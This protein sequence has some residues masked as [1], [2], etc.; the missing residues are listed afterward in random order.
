MTLGSQ[1]RMGVMMAMMAGYLIIYHD[2]VCVCRFVKFFVFLR[3]SVG[4]HVRH[5]KWA[6]SQEGQ[7]RPY[8]SHEKWALSWTWIRQI[9]SQELDWTS[10]GSHKLGLLLFPC[11]APEACNRTLRK[12]TNVIRPDDPFYAGYGLVMMM[13]TMIWMMTMFTT[14]RTS[15]SSRLSAAKTWQSAPL[16]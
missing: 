5:E 11:W 8:V 2:L 12:L 14:R 1:N 4:L 7:L 10:F 9:I 16:L 6:L 15:V 13:M 3:R